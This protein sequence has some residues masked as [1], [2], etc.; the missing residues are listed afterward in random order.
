MDEAESSSKKALQFFTMGK[1]VYGQGLA[2]SQLGYIY[3]TIWQL[4]DAKS[5][6][7][8]AMNF[9]KKAQYSAGEKYVADELSYVMVQMKEGPSME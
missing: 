8:Q 6:F 4:H 3:K 5:M 2:L 7:E 9:Y 1:Y